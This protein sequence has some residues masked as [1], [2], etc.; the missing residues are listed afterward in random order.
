[1]EKKNLTQIKGFLKMGYSTFRM[2]KNEEYR[3]KS[4]ENIILKDQEMYSYDERESD[5]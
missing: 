3:K 5:F 1:M 2:E 4:K